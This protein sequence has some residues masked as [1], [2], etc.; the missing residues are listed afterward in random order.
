[1]K[2]VL[3]E[4]KKKE[5]KGR[6]E[7]K[8][9]FF[10]SILALF[11]FYFTSESKFFFLLCNKH[12]TNTPWHYKLVPQL[13]LSSSLLIEKKHFSDITS[14]RQEFIVTSNIQLPKSEC[15]QVIVFMTWTMKWEGSLDIARWWAL[16][17]GKKVH[18]RWRCSYSLPN[19]FG[20]GGTDFESEFR[21]TK[22]EL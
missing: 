16:A 12:L 21:Q 20:S 11:V 18:F 10:W 14:T 9:N 4:R 1:M 19:N 13:A 17:A 15:W 6:W 7:R 8:V 2:T 22:M 3:I 5:R